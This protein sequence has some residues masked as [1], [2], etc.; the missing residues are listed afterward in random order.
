M[1]PSQSLSM[2]SQSS[3]QPPGSDEQ[4]AATA[5]HAV[6]FG[7]LH[8]NVPVCLQAPCV[9][10]AAS[11]LAHGLP[12]LATFS[13]TTPSQSLSSVSQISV[14]VAHVG[15]QTLPGKEQTHAP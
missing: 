1:S 5:L 3:V 8:W 6:A 4:F 2:P 13:L 14:A 7:P 10:G 11:S 15:L 9:P 12:Q